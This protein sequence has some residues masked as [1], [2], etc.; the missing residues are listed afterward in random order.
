ML[1]LNDHLYSKPCVFLLVAN[2]R[3]LTACFASLSI[4]SRAFIVRHICITKNNGAFTRGGIYLAIT[5]DAGACINT[6]NIGSSALI[7]EELDL[8]GGGGGGGFKKH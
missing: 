8:E 3:G 2:F 1:Y 5:H 6:P 4:L 7:I